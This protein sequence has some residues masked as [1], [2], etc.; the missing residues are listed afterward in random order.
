M[1]K[2]QKFYQF[3][4]DD[5][6][7]P[8]NIVIDPRNRWVQK[9]NVIPWDTLEQEYQQLF[10]SNKGK[11]AKPFRLL[12]GALIIKQT[13]QFSDKELI[14]QI[15]EN[16]YFQYFIGLHSYQYQAPFLASTLSHFRHR[17]SPHL[18]EMVQTFI[19]N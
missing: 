11:I 8:Q 14:E 1:Y 4:L 17:I 10:S 12:Y 5:F 2:K 7:M 3:S 15:K 19:H 18:L 9:A 13:Y 16:P 6:N